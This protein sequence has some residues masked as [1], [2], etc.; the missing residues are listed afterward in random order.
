[1]ESLITNL[2]SEFENFNIHDGG[3]NMAGVKIDK[4]ID[5]EDFGRIL[6]QGG[7]WG[8]TFVIFAGCILATLS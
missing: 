4:T 8:H 6:S 7:Y 3:F 2:R 5:I 1:L